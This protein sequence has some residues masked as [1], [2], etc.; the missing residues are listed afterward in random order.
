MRCFTLCCVVGVVASGACTGTIGGASGEKTAPGGDVDMTPPGG[1]VV[2]PAPSSPPPTSCAPDP[3]V[4]RVTVHRLNRVEYNN[5]VRDLLGDTTAPAN[6]FDPDDAL[7]GFDNNSSVLSI[8]FARLEQY[9]VVA[10][11]LAARAVASP[12]FVGCNAAVVG[13][14]ACA[15]QILAPF[16]KRAWR[17]PITVD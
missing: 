13:R 15:R 5:T 9:E 3:A 6:Q 11:R 2:P 17:R 14:E 7:D 8:N 12:G 4:Q 1:G 10:Q 16:L